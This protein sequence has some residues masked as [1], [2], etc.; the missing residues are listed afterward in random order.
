MVRIISF[1]PSKNAEGQ[2]FFSLQLQGDIEMVQSNQTGQFYAT[3]RTCWITS[4]FDESTCQSLIGTKLPG[5]IDRVQADPYE[6]IVPETGE[7]LTLTY[8]WAYV[9]QTTVTPSAPVQ[10]ETLLDALLS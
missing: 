6:Y 10:E 7:A 2:P 5:K 3:A 1:K 9:P 8:R 4:T